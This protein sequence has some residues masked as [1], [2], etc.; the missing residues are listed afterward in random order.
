V[1]AFVLRRTREVN[2]RY[3]PPL[4]NY[5]VFCRW[6]GSGRG[7]EGGMVVVETRSKQ[8]LWKLRMQKLL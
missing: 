1:E 3:L 6:H 8:M 5:V 2:A 4:S 7:S